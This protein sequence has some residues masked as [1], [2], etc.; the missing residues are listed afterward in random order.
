MRKSSR[1]MNTFQADKPCCWTGKFFLYNQEFSLRR[2]QGNYI[3]H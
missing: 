3:P 2:E 1:F